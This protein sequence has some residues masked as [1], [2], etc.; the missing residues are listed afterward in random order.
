MTIV[1]AFLI[2]FYGYLF[3][4]AEITAC[5]VIGPKHPTCSQREAKIWMTAAGDEFEKINDEWIGSASTHAC[6]SQPLKATL[7]SL[8]KSYHT[9]GVLFGVQKCRVVHIHYH[10]NGWLR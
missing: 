8:L 10:D 3:R 5:L 7:L 6:S 2:I 1:W 4:S 9:T